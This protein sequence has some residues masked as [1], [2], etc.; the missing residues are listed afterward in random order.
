[1]NDWWDDDNIEV[2]DRIT[3][4][5]NEIRRLREMIELY[6]RA[7]RSAALDELAAES[8]KLGLYDV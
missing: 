2:S 6:H 5:Q 1:M 4:M 3:A 8:Q 7:S